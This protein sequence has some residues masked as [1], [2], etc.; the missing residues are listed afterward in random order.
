MRKKQIFGGLM[1]I[2][3]ALSGILFVSAIGFENLFYSS[4]YLKYAINFNEETLTSES[5]IKIQFEEDNIHF[6]MQINV[7]RH[8][9]LNKYQLTSTLEDYN[10]TISNNYKA[11]RNEGSK[12]ATIKGTIF[13]L[14]DG[15]Y[16][17]RFSMVEDWIFEIEIGGI[18]EDICVY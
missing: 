4:G 6:F 16:I 11:E 1:L 13:N 12:L 15:S 2:S 7:D 10:L 17:L 8:I 14:E 3:V 9:K 18:Q 5:Y